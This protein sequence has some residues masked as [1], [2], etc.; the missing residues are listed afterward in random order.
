MQPNC[1][2]MVAEALTQ[3]HTNVTVMPDS[4][5]AVGSGGVSCCL[6]VHYYASLHQQSRYQCPRGLRR[7]SAA[8]GLLLGLRVRILPGA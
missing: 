7:G 2:A 4:W 5:T 1:D 3:T 6:P 8:A